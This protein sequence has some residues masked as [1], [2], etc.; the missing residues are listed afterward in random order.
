[1]FAGRV[2]GW[3]RLQYRVRIENPTLSHEGA[4]I[5]AM[6]LVP[7]GRGTNRVDYLRLL[8]D[9]MRYVD[10]NGNP[11]YLLTYTI[12][13]D[14]TNYTDTIEV[15]LGTQELVVELVEPR[16]YTTFDFLGDPVWDVRWQ[17]LRIHLNGVEIAHPF[18]GER[19][20]LT[21]DYY[22]ASMPMG[23]AELSATCEAGIPDL[24]DYDNCQ[25]TYTVTSVAT[26][27]VVGGYR[28]RESDEW[29]E[30]PIH[31]EI[32]PLLEDECDTG[33]DAL[34]PEF[35]G[36]TT[37]NASI[38]PLDSLTVQNVYHGTVTCEC[39]SEDG[40]SSYSVE[41]QLA[42]GTYTEHS[43][44]GRLFILP[45]LPRKFVAIGDV[46]HEYLMYRA[47]LPSVNA[48]RMVSALTSE[49]P[50]NRPTRVTCRHENA[51]PYPLHP[52]RDELLYVHDGSS[53]NPLSDGLDDHVH[54]LV[55]W[56]SS[57]QRTISNGWCR[58]LLCPVE[59]RG[60]CPPPFDFAYRVYSLSRTQSYMV[61]AQCHPYYRHTDYALRYW[62]THA[63]PM[64]SYICWLQNW[65]LDRDGDGVAEP[66]PVADYWRP[67]QC[68]HIEHPALPS[69]IRSKR[70][71]Y[72]LL[73]ALA[74]GTWSAWINDLFGVPSG[75][76]GSTRP[77]LV[78][79]LPPSDLRLASDSA[80]R[81]SVTGA[82][83]AFTPLGI[84]VT[85]TSTTH[86]LEFALADW[87]A[88]PYL[89][90]AVADR[91]RIWLPDTAYTSL[92][93][94]LV[95]A[96]NE[97]LTIAT[98]RGTHPIPHGD[99]A[100]YAG[101]WRR[102]YAASA[103]GYSELGN[104]WDGDGV[105]E[106]TFD[107][108]AR[109]TLWQLLA[110]RA[111]ARLRITITQTVPTPYVM[112]YPTFYRDSVTD[113]IAT[114]NG[115]H[116]YPHVRNPQTL[117]WGL[118]VYPT[119]SNTPS[120]RS[121]HQ[122]MTLYDAAALYRQL[123]RGMDA[124]ATIDIIDQIR[125]W[126][127]DDV[128]TGGHPAGVPRVRQMCRAAMLPYTTR[129]ALWLINDLRE[130]PP[131]PTLPTRRYQDAPFGF[132]GDWGQWVY[133]TAPSYRYYLAPNEPAKLMEVQG[134]T[135]TELTS[136]DRAVGRY[137][138]TRQ[139]VAVDGTETLQHA[140]KQWRI[141]AASRDLGRTTPFFSHAFVPPR[142][143]KP[144]T[145][146]KLAIDTRRQYLHVAVGSTLRTYHLHSRALVLQREYDGRI[147]CLE[148]DSRLDALLIVVRSAGERVVYLSRDAGDT[149]VE[150]LRVSTAGLVVCAVS[151]HATWCAFY[152]DAG[153]ALMLRRTRDGGATWDTAQQV[154]ID[155][156][157]ATGT[158]LDAVYDARYNGL[159]LVYE[160][161]G[162]DRRV[163]LSF[164]AGETFSTILS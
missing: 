7:Y 129:L 158:P 106:A 84:T 64:W 139:A 102:Q 26:A 126:G 38:V 149:A 143:A 49:T 50:W 41:L 77:A 37:W 122:P 52:Q 80:S 110:A 109:A 83:L 56:S 137:H 100:K 59:W 46:P 39:V 4:R 105:S 70:R 147:E 89:Y 51:Q 68:Q 21:V 155:G 95:S 57:S 25:D 45:D 20:V 128:E 63:A 44:S 121:P 32:P 96:E 42:T 28:C 15:G 81:W 10:A 71:S 132:T 58:A 101:T 69:A 97:T 9:Y 118:L 141:R 92:T 1:M 30:F 67:H 87:D 88:P 85:P 22:P 135:E 130:C 48:T 93:I 153:N 74:N 163:A 2:G 142:I 160:T 115:A 90:P 112:E 146:A 33:L 76:V 6:L 134:S 34:P 75:W 60:S 156:A 131:L 113:A 53:S 55:M 120:V 18:G 23:A 133:F 61:G 43:R 154:Q 11:I 31:Y 164:D 104:D 40:S 107:D 5:I 16:W 144:E 152:Q 27:R 65:G 151:P 86:T 91:V 29:H 124:S 116:T 79:W 73:D 3:E 138:L 78:E 157:S 19:S 8:L 125:A 127:F 24:N 117:N 140:T 54:S 145:G 98:T 114:D 108:A 66:T 123:E 13:L 119:A 136:Y 35:E 159:V 162:G 103:A 47:P 72:L 82:T 148:R 111:G 150:V 161:T 17:D 62:N 14:A 36:D 12:G 94:Q 99:D